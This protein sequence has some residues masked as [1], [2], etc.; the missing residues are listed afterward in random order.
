[1]RMVEYEQGYILPHLLDYVVVTPEK[2]AFHGK[3]G[4]ELEPISIE[5]A[6]KRVM[7]NFFEENGWSIEDVSVISINPKTEQELAMNSFAQK[8]GME[9][10]NNALEWCQEISKEV[11]R[12]KE[13]IFNN[14]LENSKG[15]ESEN[16]YR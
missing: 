16:R 7:Y 15:L 13:D 3:I 12:K 8:V 6:S 4:A 5:E 9:P 14:I 1:M 11:L 2:E 10:L